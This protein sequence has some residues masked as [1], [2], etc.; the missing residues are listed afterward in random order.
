[1]LASQATH[2]FAFRTH[3]DDRRASQVL[4]IQLD[5]GLARCT[6]NP[7]AALLKFF[8][9]AGQIGHGHQRNHFR[10]AAGDFSHSRRQGCRLVL[11]HDDSQCAGRIGSTQASAQV[12]RISHA[13]KHQQQW[14][15]SLRSSSSSSIAS[16]Q[17]WLGLT[18]AT[19]P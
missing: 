10:S 19:T 17:T 13:I 14:R 9:R 5:L 12:M 2:A 8:Q 16:P 6:D 11:G 18:S 15:A 1:M 7:Q 4:L 3:D